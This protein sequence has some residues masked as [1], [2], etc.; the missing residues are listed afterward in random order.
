MKV[1]VGYGGVGTEIA[2]NQAELQAAIARQGSAKYGLYEAVLGKVEFG[3]FFIAR[4]GKLLG[5]FCGFVSEEPDL[6]VTKG[7]NILASQLKKTSCLDIDAVSPTIHVIKR[8]IALSSYNG[9]GCVNYK[10]VSQNGQ[11]YTFQNNLHVYAKANADLI[12]TEFGSI[13]SA[14]TSHTE[15]IPKIFEINSRMCHSFSTLPEIFH[16]MLRLYSAN[17]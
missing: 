15:A 7:T 11:P 5:V 9:L 10:L 13:Q 8:I 2:W 1:A 17:V 14:N 6:F 16:E 12:M 3:S 4:H